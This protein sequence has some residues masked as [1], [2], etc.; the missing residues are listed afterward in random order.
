M[1]SCHHAVFIK[2]WYLQPT[3]PPAAQLHY[4]LGLETKQDFVSIN[5]PV[6]QPP[7]SSISPVTVTWPPLANATSTKTWDC[8]RPSLHVPLLLWVTDAPIVLLAAV[9]HIYK[10]AKPLSWK[11]LASEVVTQYLIGSCDMEHRYMSLDPYSCLFK[12]ALDL[13]KW[14]YTKHC[15]AGLRFFTKAAGSSS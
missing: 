12:A 15:T 8:P 2:T 5:G 9:A 14:D 10:P 6:L 13:R 7:V 1:K 11:D 4:D 3:R